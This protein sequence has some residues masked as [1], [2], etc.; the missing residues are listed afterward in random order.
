MVQA[1][2]DGVPVFDCQ[3]GTSNGKYSIKI[4][5]LLTNQGM[6]WLGEHHG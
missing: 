2:V 4:D 5:Q 6:S 3:Y 1:K